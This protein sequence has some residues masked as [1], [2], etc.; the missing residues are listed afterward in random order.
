MHNWCCIIGACADVV[1]LQSG[2]GR[3]ERGSVFERMDFDSKARKRRQKRKCFLLVGDEKLAQ[4][5][6][7]FL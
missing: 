3:K 6:A 7:Y 2:R 1:S 4:P 5:S